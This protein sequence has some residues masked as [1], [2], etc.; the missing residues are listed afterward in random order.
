L[1]TDDLFCQTIKVF[2][3]IFKQRSL[4]YAKQFSGTLRVKVFLAFA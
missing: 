4:V 3:P 2:M 1:G